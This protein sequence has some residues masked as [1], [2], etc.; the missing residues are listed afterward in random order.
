MK[1][2]IRDKVYNVQQLK[3]N[4]KMREKRGAKEKFLNIVNNKYFML[5]VTILVFS[6]VSVIAG[7]VV[8]KGGSMNVT[9]N[10]SSGGHVGI[11]TDPVGVSMLKAS[12]TFSTTGVNVGIDSGLTQSVA[13]SNAIAA[14][15][16]SLYTT[17]TSG[18]MANPI[19]YFGGFKGNS[20]G[21]VTSAYGVYGAAEGIDGF[22]PVVTVMAGVVG[23]ADV[24]DISA[25]HAL[26][27]YGL[28]PKGN[29]GSAVNAI[30]AYLAAPTIGTNRW[31]AMFEDD[32]QI[33]SDQKLILE[34]ALG[35]KGDSYITFNS[36]GDQIDVYVNGE[37]V[38]YIDPNVTW[39]KQNLSTTGVITRTTAWNSDRNGNALDFI[40]ND[41]FD[42][43]GNINHSRYSP[44]E[45]A[46][47]TSI[48]K[49]GEEEI[50]FVPE[51]CASLPDNTISHPECDDD[52]LT[53]IIDIYE[54]VTEEGVLLDGSVAKHEQAIYELKTELCLYNNYS[55][56]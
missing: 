49:V 16:S 39:V 34:G 7:D 11:G 41:Y 22:L 36:A 24:E 38:M 42:E 17:H 25:T 15:A 13:N 50:P 18:L 2:P 32:V 8:F 6:L 5:V 4:N 43:N 30:T 9:G 56:C 20:N 47:I 14:I 28:G 23:L 52:S 48:V 21:N 1:I 54:E 26:S 3:M 37:L 44:I 12:E 19:G 10:I 51:I 33:N 29:A 53:Q 40:R 46:S 55:W 45:K 35:N 27:F 31:S